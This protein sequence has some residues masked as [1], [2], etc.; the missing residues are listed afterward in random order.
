MK[1]LIT[2]ALL[3]LV[4]VF[5]STAQFPV[6]A[7]ITLKPAAQVR[8]AYGSVYRVGGAVK[9][10]IVINAPDPEYSEEARKAHYQG[11]VVL[12]LIVDAEGMPRDV[13]VWRPLGKGLDEKA[14]EAVSKW[15]FRPATKYGTPVA[16]QINIEMQFKL[17]H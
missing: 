6:V 4:L 10:P 11:T 8:S 12:Y 15:R 1:W 9:P 5:P 2:H 17:D 7:P 16:V 3:T 14:V 13:R